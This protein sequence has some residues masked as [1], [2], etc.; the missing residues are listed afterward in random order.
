M[1]STGD[2]MLPILWQM[3]SDW[4]FAWLIICVVLVLIVSPVLWVLGCNIAD[5]VYLL[6]L[7]WRNRGRN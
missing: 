7:Y 6:W 5:F 2:M 3:I 4:W 1:D